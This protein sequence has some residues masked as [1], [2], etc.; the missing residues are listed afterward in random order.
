VQKLKNAGI[1]ISGLPSFY[2]VLQPMW[3]CSALM[4]AEDA[5]L[6]EELSQR[7]LTRQTEQLLRA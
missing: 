5:A 6:S 2:V 1:A 4:S 7:P 3:C